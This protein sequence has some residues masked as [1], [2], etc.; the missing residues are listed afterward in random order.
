MHTNTHR[1]TC[2]VIVYSMHG[3][4]TLVYMYP[5]LH[6]TIITLWLP[7]KRH[8]TTLVVFNRGK[9]LKISYAT[10]IMVHFMSKGN[11]VSF[12]H[13]HPVI[14]DCSAVLFYCVWISTILW[15]LGRIVT[16]S[17]VHY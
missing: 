3:L 7:C 12:N 8:A 10:I 11:T 1:P 16:S 9:S 5:L 17:V 6:M 13:R 15:I 4:C 14:H 2:A